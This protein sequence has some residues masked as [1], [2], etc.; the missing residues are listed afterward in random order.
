MDA[1]MDAW[2]VPKSMRHGNRL[3]KVVGALPHTAW[4]WQALCCGTGRPL[5]GTAWHWQAL[6]R[7]LRG[8][9]RRSAAYCVALADGVQRLEKMVGALP[10]T[11]CAACTYYLSIHNRLKHFC[12]SCLTHTLLQLRGR[13]HGSDEETSAEEEA[14]WIMQRAKRATSVRATVH[15]F[16]YAQWV[17]RGHYHHSVRDI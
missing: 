2:T 1:W 13:T 5:P 9:G 16:V 7:A 17:K 3:E 14:R 4:R 15:A 6:C 8:A 10:R 11:A 12:D